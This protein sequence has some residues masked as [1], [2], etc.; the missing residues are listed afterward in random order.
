MKNIVISCFDNTSVTYPVEQAMRLPEFKINVR[1]DRTELH[2]NYLYA[3]VTDEEFCF[4][5]LKRGCSMSIFYPDLYFFISDNFPE[6]T[7]QTL[8]EL[9]P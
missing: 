3:E 6:T 7:I 5:S 2:I 9:R 4:L 8:K 1:R